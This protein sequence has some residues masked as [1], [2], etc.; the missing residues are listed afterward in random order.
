MSNLEQ[1]VIIKFL[2]NENLKPDEIQSKLENHFGE[3]AYKLSTI[4]KWITR[5]RW[6]KNDYED[7]PRSGRPFDDQIEFKIQSMMEDDPFLT[8]RSIA[9]SLNV[10]D[11]LVR[12]RLHNSIGMKCLNLKFVPHSLTLEQKKIRVSFAKS[13]LSILEKHIGT[14]FHYIMTGDESWFLYHYEP[15]TQWVFSREDLEEKVDAK[16]IEKKIM[17][18]IFLNGSGFQLVV[19]KNQEEHINSDY[20]IN[21][22][23]KPLIEKCE[24]EQPPKGLNWMIHFDNAKSHVS[25]K[26]QSFLLNSIFEKMK[27]PQYSPDLAPCDFGVFGTVKNRLVG[28]QCDQENELQDEIEKILGQFSEDEIYNIFLGWMRRLRLCIQLN[29]EYVQ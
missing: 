2:F 17:V 10:S 27:H 21:K 6:G 25:K 8:S 11:W 29:G 18:T 22:V 13:M 16:H 15:Q 19:Y 12:D 26:V 5:F 4:K 24:D 14:R 7:E 20:F 9:L 28:I 23:I 3:K 1:R